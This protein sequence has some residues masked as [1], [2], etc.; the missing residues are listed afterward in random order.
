M[1][2]KR[3]SFYISMACGFVI[4]LFFQNCSKTPDSLFNETKSFSVSACSAEIFNSSAETDYF[5]KPG[6]VINF[7]GISTPAGA[8]GF[9]VINKGDINLTNRS[10]EFVTTFKTPEYVQK[11]F[12]SDLE[13]GRYEFHVSIKNGARQI[14]QTP[15]QYFTVRAGDETLPTCA[16]V[17]SVPNG[18]ALIIGQ[19][20]NYTISSEPSN[21]DGQIY[22]GSSVIATGQKTPATYS[23]TFLERGP[24][25]RFAQITTDVG[26]NV[27]CSP[28]LNY[29]VYDGLWNVCQQNAGPGGPD[30]S[31][32]ANRPCNG[33]GTNMNCTFLSYSNAPAVLKCGPCGPTPTPTPI[34]TPTPPPQPA[35]CTVTATI[36]SN[37][38]STSCLSEFGEACFANISWE[39]HNATQAV[40]IYEVSS[41]GVATLVQDGCRASGST[42]V[43]KFT[44]PTQSIKTYYYRVFQVSDCSVSQPTGLN[45]LCE[46]RVTWR[47][48]GTDRGDRR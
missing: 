40:Q 33:L 10:P 34:P 29:T 4:V 13:E 27:R 26:S 21:L 43:S 25:G 12:N 31:N 14:C 42:S 45:H 37:P 3:G 38:G 18:S 41:A 22:G 30:C 7:K 28:A 15:P 47:Y 16:L 32:Y 44:G 6:D 2:T 23:E 46:A 36:P 24:V 9:F 48:S 11:I 20:V 19:T 1:V 39:F 5:Y 35:W 8:T 17:P